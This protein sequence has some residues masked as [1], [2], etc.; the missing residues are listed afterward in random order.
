MEIANSDS[1][2]YGMAVQQ[3]WEP[4]VLPDGSGGFAIDPPRLLQCQYHRPIAGKYSVR[5]A[6]SIG[7][8]PFV[9]LK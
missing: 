9:D 3:A 4:D 8:H 7:H 5:T 1:K 2:S 6:Q